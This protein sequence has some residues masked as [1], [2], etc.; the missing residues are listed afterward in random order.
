MGRIRKG[1]EVYMCGRDEKRRPGWR[2]E[3]YGRVARLRKS[4]VDVGFEMRTK[5]K[6][7]DAANE[8]DDV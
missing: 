1:E 3:G 6:R 5:E 2:K 7:S 4:D 8:K